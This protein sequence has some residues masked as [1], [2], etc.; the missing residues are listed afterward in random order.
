MIPLGFGTATFALASLL[1]VFSH[2]VY[3]IHGEHHTLGVTY[4]QAIFTL[5]VISCLGISSLQDSTL[6]HSAKLVTLVLGAYLGSLFTSVLVY[7]AFFH[8]LRHFP[9]PPRAKLG[10]LWHSLQ[11]THGD[12]YIKLNEWHNQ[13]GEFVRIG[14]DE[15]V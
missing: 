5:Y 4:I 1:G 15:L 12:G 9:G 3:F 7:R 10:K 6:I 14:S 8:R 11:I 2:L 13:Y